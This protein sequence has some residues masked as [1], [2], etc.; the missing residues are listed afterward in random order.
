MDA[1]VYHKI[2][3][4]NMRYTP[5]ALLKFMHIKTYK[6]T[7]IYRPVHPSFESV[8]YVFRQVKLNVEKN[9]GFFNLPIWPLDHK[10]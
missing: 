3:A 1:V 6:H 4:I 2:S 8:K 9:G 5:A 7:F 10:L